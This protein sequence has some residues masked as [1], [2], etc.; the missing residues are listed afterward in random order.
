MGQPLFPT[1]GKSSGATIVLLINYV[2]SAGILVMHEALKELA[3]LNLGQLHYNEPL[4]NHSSW[5]I[6]GHA[7]LLVEPDSIQ[8]IQILMV[9][10]DRRALPFVV[11]GDGSN[12]LFDDAGVRGVVVKI[13]RN[14]SKWEIKDDAVTAEAGIFVPSL[15]RRIGNAGL[16]GFEHAIGIPGSLGGLVLMNGGSMRQNIGSRIEN[17]WA[18]DRNG[19]LLN[20]DRSAC[21]FAYRKSALQDM[22][23]VV[24]KVRLKGD[25]GNRRIIRREMLGILRSRR[26]KF[27]LKLPNCGSVFLSDPKMYD[28]AGPPGV[29]IEQCNLK[30]FRIG[31]AK[32]PNLHANFIVNL[33]AAK[34]KDILNIIHHVRD[35]VQ[36]R[37]GY[38]LMCEVRY[39]TP[40]CRLIPAHQAH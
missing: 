32:I 24:V 18:V 17:I 13:G 8:Q 11:I 28:S 34:S 19:N 15:I 26:Q 37:T 20:F 38:T 9:E 36:H 14:L 1:H 35:T 6:G 40:E 30:G 31:D 23:V 21:H 29:V 33:G 27:P 10:L 7:D 39:L 2:Y 3:N 4:R 5:R 16:C 25:L 12:I 22:G